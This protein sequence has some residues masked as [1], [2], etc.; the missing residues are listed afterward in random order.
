MELFE[1]IG[2]GTFHWDQN[3]LCIALKQL[4]VGCQKILGDAYPGS[5]VFSDT[6]NVSARGLR[7]PNK[8]IEGNKYFESSVIVYSDAYFILYCKSIILNYRI[9]KAVI[10]K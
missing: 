4:K 6:I 8:L 5:N 7:N 2:V 1:E 3:R 9:S 10:L